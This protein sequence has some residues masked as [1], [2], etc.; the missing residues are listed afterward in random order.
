MEHIFTDANFDAEVLKSSVP[1]VVDFWAEWCGPCRMMSPILEEVAGEIESSKI[2]I[3][4]M[5]VDQNQTVPGQFGI[6][7]IP[8]F[9]IFKNGMVVEQMVGSMSKAM[10]K[11]KIMKHL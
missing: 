4:K 6:M 3:G 5:N 7:S 9:L 8:T 1:V 10:F 11:E 2:K